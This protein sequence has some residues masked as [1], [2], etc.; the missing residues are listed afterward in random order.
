MGLLTWYAAQKRL[1]QLS[2]GFFGD[3]VVELHRAKGT[4]KIS[5]A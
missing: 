4:E 1:A 5:V 2:L 3:V